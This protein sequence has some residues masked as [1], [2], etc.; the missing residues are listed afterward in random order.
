MPRTSKT[1]VGLRQANRRLA[2]AYKW[3]A[4]SNTSLGSVMAFMNQTIIL[5]SLPAIFHGLGVNPL[6]PG[7][8]SLLLWVLMS[9][10]V[11]TT[12]FLV[13]FGRLSDNFGKVRFY[14]LGFVVFTLGSLMCALT[15]G[16]GSSGAAELIAFRFVQGIGGALLMSN[17]VAILTDAFPRSQRGLAMGVNQVVGISGSVLGLVAGGLLATVNW[18]L[19]FLINVPVGVVGTIWA[20]LKLR[21]IGERIPQPLDWL[22]NITFAVGLLALLSALTYALLPYGGQAMGW[23]NPW[24]EAG[25][26]AGVLLLGLFVWIESK[27]PYPMIQLS[28]FRI[29]D[30]W[31][32]NLAGFLGSLGRGG[33]QFLL[34]IWLQAVWL[35]LHGVSFAQTPFQAGV[36]TLPMLAGFVLAGPI[37]GAVSDRIGARWIATGGMVVS[38]VG[39]ALLATLSADFSFP[40]F[41]VYL[42]VLGVGM[43][44]FAAPNTASIM[45]SVPAKDRA[46]A[47]GMRATFM[48][49]AT[50][51][52][53]AVFFTMVIGGLSATLPDSLRSGLVAAGA[54]PV[55]AEQLSH[56]P[57]AAALFSAL[58]GYNPFQ[59]AVPPSVMAGLDPKLAANLMS[60]HFFSQL[61]AGPMTSSLRIVFAAGVVTSLVAALAS[62]LRQSARVE[63]VPS[64][65]VDSTPR[66][67]PKARP[68]ER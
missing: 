56:L 36:D 9:Y 62:A 2:V 3:I 22:G 4:L 16:T 35:P 44:M 20:Y 50:V 58:L 27:V 28:L 26:A 23:S 60:P 5:I 1:V 67:L 63:V 48:N 43:G 64:G 30:F 66:P 33:L 42:V 47:S 14:N 17:S 68:V 53:L 11:A 37:G 38:A 18:R 7:E 8:T 31:A 65:V 10:N 39:F 41:A 24:V 49:A 6:A 40:I 12:V 21:D 52:S 32:G 57:P 29:R 13:T 19:V 59:A 51:M 15:P 46:V 61:F 45:N 54:P 55:L 34:V 25:I